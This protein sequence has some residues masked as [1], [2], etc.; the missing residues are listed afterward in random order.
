MDKVA[1]DL[2]R[3][4]AQKRITAPFWHNLSAE[5]AVKRL[6]TDPEQGLSLGEIE[7]R[8]KKFGLN[9]LPEEKPLSKFRIFLSQF[10][11]PL[12][13]ILVLACIV[14]IYLKEYADAI[15]IF[16]AVSVNTV[17][18]F[19]Q[20][21]KASRALTELKK[22]LKVKA[23]VLRGGNEM[24][25][26]Q[27]ELVPGDIIILKPGFKV[28]AD[29]RLIEAKDI[30]VNEAVLTGEWMPADKKID[31]LPATAHLADRDNMLYMGT[32][33]ESGSGKAVVV[34]TGVRTEIGKVAQLVKETKEEETPYQK[35]L[36]H[37]SKIV[38]I[39][40]TVMCIVI[41]VDGMLRGGDFEEI[42]ITSIAVAVAAI[43]EGLPVAMT[44]ILAIG[45]QRILRRKGLVRRLASAETL[46][47]TSV[48]CTDKT[49]TLTEAKMQVSAVATGTKEILSIEG[50][51][52][53]NI[54]KD[55]P[56]SPLLTLKIATSCSDAFIENPQ[57]PVH[58]WVVRGRP[59]DRALLVAGAQAGLSKKE[60]EEKM[61]KI[62][63]LPF[64]PVYK[65]SAVL[66]EFSESEYVLFILGAPELIVGMSKHIELDGVQ[67]EISEQRS[68]ELS[69]K[70]ESYTS[71]GMRVLATAYKKI[72]KEFLVSPGV[73]DKRKLIEENLKEAVFVGFIVL[74]DPLRPEVKEAIDVCIKAGMKTIIVTGD[75]R[76]TAKAV[77][78]ELGISVEEKNILEGRELEAMNEE[79]FKNRVDEIQIYARVE[80]AQKLRIVKAW[81]E[82][83]EVVAMT[84]DGINDAPALKQADIGV[85]LG[86]G[87]DVAKEVSDLVL[88]EDNF[89]VIVAA[90]EE[91]R[92]IIDNVRKVITYLLSDSFTEVVLI[93]GSMIA[94]LPLPLTAAQILWVNLIEDGLPSIT[95]AFEPKEKDLMEQKPEKHKTPLLTKEMKTII[96][97]IG[98]I[99]DIALFGIFWWLWI[100]DHHIDHVRT[101]IFAALSIDSLFYVFACKS[102]RHNL[103][104]T[105]LLSNKYLV[106]AW[107][108]GVMM[109]FFAIYTPI[110]QTLLGTVPL[111]LKDWVIIFII[112][113]VEVFLVEIVKWHFIVKKEFI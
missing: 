98:L 46:G 26:L 33:V 56:A 101:M 80:P 7:I 18:G 70:Y 102:L 113:V 91:G 76:L 36:S 30:G 110:L 1:I 54:D 77:A 81:Q 79:E 6:S 111:D 44:A 61:P 93:G 32:V 9:K 55:S 62:D 51:Y 41:F 106:I 100:A 86:S 28:P 97:A 27:E 112:G 67:E 40:I 105:N 60:I 96:F 19:F 48:I 5:E 8:K 15:V 43:P 84:G 49:G 63:G 75:H 53:E 2:E 57:D 11:S 64:D 50:K 34:E 10:R 109:L 3:E 90:V 47:S 82:R 94:G 71:K 87:T 88:L 31:V 59:T 37:F 13:Y 39:L 20:E 108:V 12:I 42:F 78:E 72:N 21:N 99:T 38:G 29:A 16:A 45:A 65:Y 73:E 58:E 66:H 17:I 74:R 24:E 95:L 25:V 103:W 22:I 4:L 23:I 104:R 14:T 69:K 85:A 92:G 35:K 107:V 52:S 68:A 83:G 89:S